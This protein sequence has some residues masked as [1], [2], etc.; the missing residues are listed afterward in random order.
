MQRNLFCD[1]RTLM[2]VS[3]L[4]Y[5]AP[6]IRACIMSRFINFAQRISSSISDLIKVE[7]IHNCHSNIAGSFF[8]VA[9]LHLIMHDM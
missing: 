8:Y 1:P 5:D 7:Q 3:I 4:N 2:S 6:F 9:I